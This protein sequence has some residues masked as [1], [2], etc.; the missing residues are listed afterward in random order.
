MEITG[1]RIILTGAASGIGRALLAQLGDF[2]CRVLA[3]DRDA[4][5]LVAAAVECGG[6][7]A[8]IETLG[9]DLSAP[10]ATDAL[11]RARGVGWGG[12]DLFVANAG[13][14][15]YGTIGEPDW[16]KIAGIFRANVFAAIYGL[17]RMAALNPDRPYGCADMTR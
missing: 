7:R 15:Y 4:A 17:Q 2:E 16:E 12:V 9:A 8:F 6:R 14:A 11:F 3:R 10:A 1:Q 13:F 5:R